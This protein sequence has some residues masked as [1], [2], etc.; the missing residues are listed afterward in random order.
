MATPTTWEA[1]LDVMNE[2]DRIDPSSQLFRLRRHAA[3][4]IEAGETAPPP[5][6][7]SEPAARSF[8]APPP[9]KKKR[10]RGE[11]A[12]VEGENRT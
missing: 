4:E 7:P 1:V 5:A 12:H 6:P 10:K 9:P 3:K 8:S 11:N 2:N